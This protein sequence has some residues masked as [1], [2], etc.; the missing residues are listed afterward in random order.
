[1]AH[2]RARFGE[3][4][5]VVRTRQD[6]SQEKLGEL[7]GLHRTFVSMVERGHRN[8]TLA[9]VEKLAAALGCRMAD[10]MPD[11]EPARKR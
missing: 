8:V 11:P 10:L 7:A 3:R 4:L 9:T 2:I 6:L 1:L 5:R